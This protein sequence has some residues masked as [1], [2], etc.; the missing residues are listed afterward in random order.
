MHGFAEMIVRTLEKRGVII[1]DDHEIYIYGFETALYTLFSTTGLILIGLLLGRTTETLIMVTVFYINQ[2]LGGGFHASTH[3]KCFIA[4]AGGL[5]CCLVSFAFPFNPFLY[6]GLGIVSLILLF[7]YP[8]V[9]HENKRY[10]L[11]Q[12]RNL[13]RRSRFALLIQAVCLFA[14][15]LWGEQV[16]IQSFGIALFACAISRLIAVHLST[17]KRGMP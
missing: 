2:T 11:S 9:F 1:A 12:K 7:K 13:Y 4:M 14:V 16:C 6:E 17:S 8:L 15:A 3:L 5:L 10:L